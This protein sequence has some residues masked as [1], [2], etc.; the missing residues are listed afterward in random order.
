MKLR[1]LSC[2]TL[3]CRRGVQRQPPEPRLLSILR[4]ST[5]AARWHQVLQQRLRVLQI[6]RV[7]AFRKPIIN[8]SKQFAGL[9]RLALVAPEASEAHGG[10][11]FPG[12]CLLLT[13]NCERVAE[14]RFGFRGI[15]LRRLER[16]L[17]GDAMNLDLF[18]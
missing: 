13:G 11:E 12:L 14:K 2:L 15:R 7:V 18:A 17:A 3:I 9:L 1:W 10:A 5:I 16:N 6:A 8:R 4:N